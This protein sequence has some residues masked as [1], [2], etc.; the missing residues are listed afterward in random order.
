[1]GGRNV[2]LDAANKM[3]NSMFLSLWN[4][5]PFHIQYKEFLNGTMDECIA[6]V[7]HTFKTTN[8]FTKQLS[9]LELI[10]CP[11]TRTLPCWCRP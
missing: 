10:H 3:A 5:S 4:T 6:H 9:L 2:D 7:L 1:M 8:F 11:L